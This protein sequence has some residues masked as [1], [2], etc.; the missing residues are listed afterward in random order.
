MRLL[1]LLA[2]ALLVTACSSQPPGLGDSTA[3]PSGTPFN[4]PAGVSVEGELEGSA[5][6]DCVDA[7]RRG[8]GALVTVCL[9]LR[10]DTDAP[11]TVTLPPGLILI[12]QSTETQNGF[13]EQEVVIVIPARTVIPTLIS[14]Y[15]LNAERHASS[16]TDRYEL[17]PV[18]DSPGLLEITQ[19]L[20]GRELE[21]MAF[22]T[23]QTAVWE[24]T[25]YSG[26]LT[27]EARQSLSE[28]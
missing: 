16:D 28:L 9:S 21:P 23:I 10:N 5:E 4:L 25:D 14:S 13:V 7:E 12:S 18:T 2:S 22:L 11:I 27:A 6:Q 24:V 19:L 8:T 1:P 17:G 26:Q 20:A 3:R 15:C